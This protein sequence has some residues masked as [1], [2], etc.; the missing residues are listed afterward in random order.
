MD[1]REGSCDDKLWVLHMQHDIANYGLLQG[2]TIPPN[3][4]SVALKNVFLQ[5][6]IISL[7]KKIYE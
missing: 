1:E 6:R 7:V 5:H 3:Q 4:N 2:C